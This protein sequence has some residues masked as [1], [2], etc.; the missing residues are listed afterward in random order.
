[1]QNSKNSGGNRTTQIPYSN[2]LPL[3]SNQSAQ[4]YP[5]SPQ[6]IIPPQVLIDTEQRLQGPRYRTASRFLHEHAIQL[7]AV[8]LHNHYVANEIRT[9]A[10]Q[11]YNT[12]VLMDIRDHMF[13]PSR[14]QNYS[15]PFCVSQLQARTAYITGPHTS[16]AIA[17]VLPS[18]LVT[19]PVAYTPVTTTYRS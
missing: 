12:S 9:F 4:A 17:T 7:E 8:D 10:S 3:P 13:E 11:L 6:T 16:T 5:P 14:I 1:M 2:N 15:H 18:P 19:A